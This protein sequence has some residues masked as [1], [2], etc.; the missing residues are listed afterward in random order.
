MSKPQLFRYT[1][2]DRIMAAF[3]VEDGDR[4]MVVGDPDNGSYEWVIRTPTGIDR[5]SDDGYGIPGIALR[6]ALIAYYGLPD[7]VTA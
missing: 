3:A 7:E 2:D 4:V 1:H 6:D 5:H